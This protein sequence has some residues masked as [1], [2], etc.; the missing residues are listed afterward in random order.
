MEGFKEFQGKDLD[1]AIEEACGYFNTAREKLEIE[2]VQDAK[3]GIFGIV[4]ARKAKVRARRVQLRETMESILGRKNGE[5]A[6]A[7][8]PSAGQPASA[9]ENSGSVEQ[10][11][12]GGDRQEQAPTSAPES[13]ASAAPKASDASNA[14]EAQAEKGRGDGRDRQ[15]EARPQR[16]PQ[17]DRRNPQDD[18]RNRGRNRK[19]QSLDAFES[20]EDLDAAI[21]GN[22]LEKPA[23][24]SLDRRGERSGKPDRNGA[25]PSGRNSRNDRG[26][27]HSGRNAEGGEGVEAANPAEP[28]A[29]EARGRRNDSRPDN[30]S[31][32]R[33]DN[34]GNG[35]AEARAAQRENQRPERA[36]RPEAPVEGLEDDFEAAGEGLPVTP[37][38]QLDVAKLETLVDETV[39]KLIRPI[40]GDGVGITVKI[41]GGRVYVG[42]DCDEDSG[43][44]IGREGQTLAALQYMISRIVSRGMNAAVRVQLDAGEYRRRQDEKL[45]EMALALAD[46]VRQSG[47]SYSTRP[48]SSYHR[49]IVHVCLQ[50]AVDVQTRSTGDGPM[51]RVVIMRRKGER[52]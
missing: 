15:Q 19:P 39:R 11:K 22:V 21:N 49:R 28:P 24:R 18:R 43:L 50:E 52:A 42:I 35:R 9:S 20:E 45:R 31:D 1:S 17:G 25:K 8:A 2:I 34:R 48:L 44:L 46:K 23:D 5:G 38:E 13:S 47:R 41:G 4:G 29:R 27:D 26:R 7:P 36:P 37:L 40:T 30:R 10:R 6:S 12:N 51:K 14:P 33:S 16:N 32:N 3:S